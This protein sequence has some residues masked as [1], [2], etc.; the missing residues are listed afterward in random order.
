MPDDL[1]LEEPTRRMT[2]PV[3]YNARG[4]HVWQRD[5]PRWDLYFGVVL[6]VTE[7]FLWLSDGRG[8]TPRMYAAA[9]VLLAL[10]LYLLL[11]RPAMRNDPENSPRTMAYI[12]GAAVLFVP[13]AVLDQEATIAM[14]ALGPQCFMLLSIR[15]AMLSMLVINFM[16]LIGWSALWHDQYQ[17]LLQFSVL[18]VLITAFSLAFGGWIQRIVDQSRDRAELIR[19]LDE[20]RDEVARLSAAHGALSERERL[21]REIHDTLAQGFTSVIMLSQAVESELDHDLEQARRHVELVKE[22]ARENLAES[23]TLVAALSPAQLDSASLEEA[24]RRLAER[25]AAELGV[26]ITV[27]VEG[28]PRR[29]PPAVEVVALR[30]CQEALANIRKHAHAR[31]VAVALAYAADGLELTIVDDGRGFDPAARSGGY[32]LPGMRARVS[33]IGGTAKVCSAPGEGTELTIRL[34]VAASPD[35]ISADLGERLEPAGP[36][37]SA[38]RPANTRTTPATDLETTR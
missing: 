7:I 12:C 15:R 30:T 17:R 10:P 20:S 33:E 34:P 4:V 1:P 38:A 37:R 32:G 31:E 18:T 24:V 11:G 13:A 16:P 14:F 2:A 29:L 36:S 3:E 19:Q 26:A 35:G 6:V 8:H 22:T 27:H 25:L 23:R 9:L 28:T 21:A 5:A